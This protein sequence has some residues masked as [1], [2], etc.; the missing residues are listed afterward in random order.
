MSPA[1]LRRLPALPLACLVLS[2]AWAGSALIRA[3]RLTPMAKH[4][5]TA[6]LPGE[7][8]HPQRA[9]PRAS[10]LAATLDR[11][12]F[13][14]ERRRPTQPFLMP[15]EEVV[16][17]PSDSVAAPAAALRLVGTAV[18]GEGGF[19]MCQWGSEPPRLVRVGASMNQLTLELVAPG[20]AVFRASGGKRIELRVAKAGT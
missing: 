1:L 8:A 2:V 12:P 14:P 16:K 11:N 18:V 3:V 17:P 4:A 19:A 7:F 6:A 13:H 15:G 9:A 10:I 20:R 5:A